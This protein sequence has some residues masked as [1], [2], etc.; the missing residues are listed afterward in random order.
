MELYH[1]NK[2]CTG[3]GINFTVGA[4][5]QK[6]YISLV[7]QK[8]LP[9]LF[10]GGKDFVISI[11]PTEMRRF[12]NAIERKVPWS[13][14][15]KSAKGSLSIE[16]KPHSYKEKIKEKNDKGVVVEV[17]KEFH[18]GLSLGVYPKGGADKFGF[19]FNG[20]EARLFREFLLFSI[21]KCVA[22]DYADRKAEFK[23][24]QKEEKASE[25]AEPE[26]EVAEEPETQE[27]PASDEDSW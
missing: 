2:F 24:S 17:W 20:A 5:Q 10:S 13:G 15:H 4:K 9:N 22:S 25:A 1:P 26:A 27:A 14:F 19:A 12:L 16:L 7:N 18:D 21:E 6:V 8:A 23:N 3:T 11:N